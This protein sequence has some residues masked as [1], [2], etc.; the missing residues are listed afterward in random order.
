MFYSQ[1]YTAV[2]G[3]PVH[4]SEATEVW[5]STS[6]GIIF[7][8]NVEEGV[9]NRVIEVGRTISTMLV[10]EDEVRSLT[11]TSFPISHSLSLR[12]GAAPPKERF[13]GSTLE[14]E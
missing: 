10:V 11:C 3:D 13:C 8:W 9:V 5:E 4:G 6:L 14:V 12:F 1:I 7:V 2:V